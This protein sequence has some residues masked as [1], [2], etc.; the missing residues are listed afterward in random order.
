M[1]QTEIY[2]ISMLEACEAAAPVPTISA[3]LPLSPAAAM[4]KR[5]EGFL[6]RGRAYPEWWN[7]ALNLCE[8]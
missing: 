2:A 3:M 4:A 8:K 7:D 5:E 6:P 1:G